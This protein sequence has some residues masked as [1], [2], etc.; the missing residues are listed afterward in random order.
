MKIT[1]LNGSA[2]K[3][4]T[5]TA[6][7]AFVEGTSGKHEVTII[8]PDKL[9][10]HPCKGCG[11]CQ[12]QNGCIDQDDTN[13]TIDTIAASDMILFATPVYWWGMTA[14]LKQV[15]DKCYCRGMQLKGKKIAVIVIGGAPVGD[16]QYDLIQ[17]QFQCMADYLSWDV[18]FQKSY[19]ANSTTDLAHDE[20]IIAELKQLGAE[21]Q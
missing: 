14:Q 17:K 9:Q 16:V 13:P 15:I 7:D 5:H 4:N 18:L 10:I 2:R 1:I 20:S 11:A 12:C 8:E 19:S 3:G 6:I 21:I